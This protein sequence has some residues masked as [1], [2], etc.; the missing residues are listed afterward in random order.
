MGNVD[1]IG[2]RRQAFYHP[3]QL[4]YVGINRPVVSEKG[5]N[6]LAQD[7]LDER[8]KKCE[9]NQGLDKCQAQDPGIPHL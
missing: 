2:V 6:P 9:Q 7:L 5:D 3:F 1:D 4:T 8:D